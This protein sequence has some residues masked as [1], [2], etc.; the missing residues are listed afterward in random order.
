MHDELH[1]ERKGNLRSFDC[2]LA[3]GI[4]LIGEHDFVIDERSRAFVLDRL[5]PIRKCK[6]T[7]R[8]EH[9]HSIQAHVADYFGILA[10]KKADTN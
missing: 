3:V 4:L 10:A 6:G 9:A 2:R 7:A 1:G 5:E 8:M